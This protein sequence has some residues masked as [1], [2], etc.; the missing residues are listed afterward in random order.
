MPDEEERAM[1]TSAEATGTR[2][3]VVRPETTLSE[4]AALLKRAGEVG[5]E[6]TGRPAPEPE[7]DAAEDVPLD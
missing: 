4:L 1:T 2:E 5:A 3:I 7:R 6:R